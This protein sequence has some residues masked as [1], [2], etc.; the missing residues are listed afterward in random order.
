RAGRTLSMGAL[1]ALVALTTNAGARIFVRPLEALTVPLTSTQNTGAQAIVV[2]AAG[3]VE[4]APEYDGKDIPD[5]IALARLRYTAKLQHETG[6]PVLISGG[7]GTPDGVVEPLTAATARA[8]RT[9]F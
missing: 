5:Y 6:L 9:D 1:L 4:N 3:R 2:L 7:N 8:L